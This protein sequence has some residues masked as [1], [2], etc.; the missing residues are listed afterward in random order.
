M[1]ILSITRK[2]PPSIGGMQTQSYEF[3]QALAK[4]AGVHLIAWGGSQV[5][6]PIFIIVAMV[7]GLFCLI[8][9][10]IDV[11][12]VGDLVLSPVALLL[13]LLSGKTTLAMAHGRDTSTDTLAYRKVVFASSRKL[14]GIICVSAFLKE[15]LLKR[16]INSNR[17]FVNPNGIDI[18]GFAKLPDKNHCLKEV[19][20]RLGIR[21]EG[22]KVLLS[23][24]RLVRKKGMAHFVRHILP[25]IVKAV[26]ETVLILAG[27]PSCK[28]AKQ[29][30][31]DII[32]AVAKNN[33]ENQV[34]FIGNIAHNDPL[35]NEIY[36]TAD[37]F[38]MPNQHIV[39]D[40]EGFGI[41]ALEASINEVPVVA[42]A[43]DGITEAVKE[44][45]NG[46][47]IPENDNAGFA[48]V[49][50]DL[51][52]DEKKRKILGAKARN[53]VINNFSWDVIT[54]RYLEIL[55]RISEP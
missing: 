54:D 14:D 13:K 38:V 5:F 21:L 44:K 48:A 37:L 43:V 8:R 20:T 25:A 42:F 7:R 51:L 19:K 29:E 2:F 26:P 16:G 17:L 53:F 31:A 23:V 11:I 28:E 22:K 52:A 24:S 45:C 39:S 46:I 30:K 6:L 9:N 10:Q 47:L 40:Y 4:K 41:V 1:K 3:Q 15:E 18:Y 32:S 33:L 36:R 50:I 34:L 55:N 27:E 49:V 12:Q 35:L